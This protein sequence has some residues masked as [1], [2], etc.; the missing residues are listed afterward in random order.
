MVTS[1]A[2]AL[3]ASLQ[4]RKVRLE[5]PMLTVLASLPARVTMPKSAAMAPRDND[6]Q[7]RMKAA[8]WSRFIG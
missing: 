4:T 7:P 2:P 3:F 5:P 1:T 6:M 8:I